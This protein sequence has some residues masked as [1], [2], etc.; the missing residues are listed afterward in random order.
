MRA[1]ARD[2]D[3]HGAPHGRGEPLRRLCGRL[4]AMGVPSSNMAGMARTAIS[5][6]R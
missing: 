6:P 4:P 3:Q 2:S 1:M 5:G